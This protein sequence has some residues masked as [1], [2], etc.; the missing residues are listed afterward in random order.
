MQ[1]RPIGQTVIDLVRDDPCTDLAR[2]VRYRRNFRFRDNRAGRVGGARQD[3]ALRRRRQ[4]GEG[5]GGQLEALGLAAGDFYRFKVQG[6]DGIA[7]GHITRPGER[8]PVAGLERGR[9]CQHEC[10]RG[11]AGDRDAVGRDLHAVSVE[12]VLRDAG[13]QRHALPVSHGFA[14]EHAVRGGDGGLRRAGRWLAEFHVE[15]AMATRFQFMRAA[16]Y[17]D[18]L[19]R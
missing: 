1:L 11:A 15:D 12:I 17:G 4:R 13:L 6:A 9:Q 8:D 7:I 5:V 3:D 19:E 10:R 16:T 18:R 2:D 14:V